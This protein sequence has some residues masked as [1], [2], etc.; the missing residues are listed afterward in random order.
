[1]TVLWIAASCVA[2]GATSAANG[3]IQPGVGLA[4]TKLGMTLAQTKKVLGKPQ[5]VNARLQL[6]GHR[7]YIEYG[8]NYSST[9]VGFMPTKRV[10]RSVLIG[11]TLAREKTSAGLGVGTEVERL[12]GL[13]RMSCFTGTAWIAHPYFAPQQEQFPHCVLAGTD[14]R[15]TIFV[16]RCVEPVNLGCHKYFVKQVIVRSN[17]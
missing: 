13:P 10:L 17:F 8:W 16:L 9:W 1:M 15:R 4:H 5:T 3:T 11:T 2:L 6:A 7:R 12:R 14:Q